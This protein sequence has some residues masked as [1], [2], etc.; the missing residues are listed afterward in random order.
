MKRTVTSIDSARSPLSWA[1]R[2]AALGYKVIPLTPG[3]K[4]PLGRLVP[5]G[6]ND[7]TDNPDTIRAWWRQMPN[8]GIGLALAASG[9][10]ALDIDPRNGGLLTLEQL[11]QQHGRI[12]S[13]VQAITGGGG[14]HFVFSLPAG[15]M[16]G[17]PGALG[18]GLDVKLNGYICVEPSVHPSGRTYEWEASSSPLDGVAP[19]P[20]PDWLRG[21]VRPASAAPDEERYLPVS[22]AQWAEVAEALPYIPAVER[23]QWVSVGMALQSTGRADAF[24]RWDEWSRSCP[25]K[26]N[27]ADQVRVWKSFAG[28]GL[29]GVT[30]T[31]VFA[32]AKQSGWRS[33]GAAAVPPASWLLDMAALSERAGELTWAVKHVIPERS[34]GMLFGASG[35]FKSFLAIDYALHRCYGLAWLGRKTR[36]GLVVYLAAEGGTGLLRRIQAWHQARDMDWRACPMRVCITPLT[37]R[38]QARA[39][40]EQVRAVCPGATDVI[41]DTLSQTYTGNENAADEMADYLRVVGHELRLAL[42]LHVMLIHHAGH[43]ATERPRGSSAIAANIDYLLGAFRDEKEMLATLCCLKQKDGELFEDQEFSLSRLQLGQDGD[44]D[45]ITSLAARCLTNGAEIAEAILA[46]RKSG[47]SGHL[48]AMLEVAQDGMTEGELR[49]AFYKT[50]PESASH[51]L[52]KKTFKRTRDRAVAAGLMLIDE[53]AGYLVHLIKPVDNS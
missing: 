33:S 2:Y 39:L 50:L 35:A 8:A 18:P 9:L 41:V 16:S 20:M 36:R 45:P 51:D 14:L 27:H 17:L 19:D 1:L 21:Y 5:Q 40:A 52:R 47:R 32:R 15:A 6:V 31:A 44:G 28:R 34:L 22:D 29:D 46:E 23:E 42:D 53:A 10:V 37:L 11:E 7:A 49:Q 4:T 24:T 43:G 38:T 48:S 30:Y 25:A 26:Y 13:S 3:Q 12:E